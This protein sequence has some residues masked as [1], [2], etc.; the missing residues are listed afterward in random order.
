MNIAQEL[1]V[2][3]YYEEAD[4]KLNSSAGVNA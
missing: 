2:V 3:E 4:P 1:R